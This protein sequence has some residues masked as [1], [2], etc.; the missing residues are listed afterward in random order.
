MRTL[1]ATLLTTAALLFVPPATGAVPGP[2]LHLEWYDRDAEYADPVMIVGRATRT[3]AKSLVYVQEA[4]AGSWVNVAKQRVDPGRLF[5][6]RLFPKVGR[7]YYRLHMPRQY[8]QPAKRLYVGPTVVTRRTVK[9]AMGKPRFGVPFN[10]TTAVFSGRLDYARPGTRVVLQVRTGD[11]W[12]TKDSAAVDADDSFSLTTTTPTTGAPTYRVVK[13]Q[14][15]FTRFAAAEVRSPVYQHPIVLNRWDDSRAYRVT[16]EHPIRLQF[17][18]SAGVTLAIRSLVDDWRLERYLTSYLWSWDGTLVKTWSGDGR[19]AT[20]PRTGTYYLDL[21]ADPGRDIVLEPYVAEAENR[22]LDSSVIDFVGDGRPAIAFQAGAGELVSL[23]SPD[24]CGNVLVG[25][26]VGMS[27][28]DRTLPGIW[29]IP[30][31]GTYAVFTDRCSRQGRLTRAREVAADLDEAITLEPMGAY[32][33]TVVSFEATAGDEVHHEV[34]P[35]GVSS[36]A[37]TGPTGTRYGP[38]IERVGESGTHYYTLTSYEGTTDSLSFQI[39][40]TPRYEG[41]LTEGSITVDTKGCRFARANVQFTGKAG[42]YLLRNTGDRFTGDHCRWHAIEA[43]R[44][45]DC[46]DDPMPVDRHYEVTMDV[47]EPRD[48]YLSTPTRTS[49]PADSTEVVAPLGRPGQE[50]WLRVDTQP[51]GR[52][53]LVLDSATVGDNYNVWQGLGDSSAHILNGVGGT[54]EVEFTASAD[55][56]W[57][58]LDRGDSDDVGDFKARVSPV[59]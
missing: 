33:P 3:H 54:T 46:D 41:S 19:A 2:Q 34:G 40:K 1:L 24:H 16:D 8:G 7:H 56:V 22:E 4:R 32:Q 52:Y 31:D 17:Q 53:R 51:G 57:L 58:R 12:S 48:L 29:R 14:D 42:E 49:A 20:L 39:C 5:K 27:A 45:G 21:Y 38:W 28:I 44:W 6:F 9:I 10:G 37:L 55:T 26:G 35:P 23:A 47:G 15:A 13:A 36:T 25:T 11:T 18:S 59:P 50:A 30:A 43:E